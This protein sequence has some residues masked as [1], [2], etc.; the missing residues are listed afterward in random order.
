[1]AIIVKDENNIRNSNLIIPENISKNNIIINELAPAS[2][3]SGGIYTYDNYGTLWRIYRGA[4]GAIYVDYL[5]WQ[6]DF[7]L[8]EYIYY[9]HNV[10]SSYS[11]IDWLT[12]AC[13]FFGEDARGPFPY[14][15]T[16][17]KIIK[18]TNSGLT[19]EYS[20]FG[21]DKPRY[22]YQATASD[23]DFYVI[24]YS[25]EASN[26]P[27]NLKLY[28]VTEWQFHYL[29]D[30][31]SNLYGNKIKNICYA[32]DGIHILANIEVDG[33]TIIKHYL[34][35]FISWVELDD[36]TSYA[37][38]IHIDCPGGVVR[39][40]DQ[41]FI[42]SLDST[43]NK[44]DLYEY[45]YYSKNFKFIK[46]LNPDQHNQTILYHPIIVSDISKKDLIII[47]R[48]K[49]S[50][51]SPYMLIVKS[52][53][54]VKKNILPID[55]SWNE[56]KGPRDQEN[57]KL[58]SNYPSNYPA[59]IRNPKYGDIQIL[60]GVV[61]GRLN[62]KVHGIT[63]EGYSSNYSIVYRTN[64]GNVVDGGMYYS[65]MKGI[66]V[67]DDKNYPS[68]HY[69]YYLGPGQNAKYVF[70]YN[71]SLCSDTNDVYLTLPSAAQG[72]AEINN[73]WHFIG[74]GSNFVKHYKKESDSLNVIELPDMP[75]GAQQALIF[76]FNNKIY[77]LGG[78]NV[79]ACVMIYENNSWVFYPN[80]LPAYINTATHQFEIMGDRIYII[81]KSAYAGN[82]WPI[83][84]CHSKKIN[85]ICNTS[86]PWRTEPQMPYAVSVGNAYQG[87]NTVVAEKRLDN[88]LED[89]NDSG[90][91][92]YVFFS[93]LDS[94]NT[95]RLPYCP[96]VE[97]IS[98]L[99]YA[100]AA[101]T[102]VPVPT[103]DEYGNCHIEEQAKKVKAVWVGGPDNK[104]KRVY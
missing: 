80:V 39:C 30:I 101:W 86:I 13:P 64:Y 85:D 38:N 103:Y 5:T 4:G 25:E 10:S 11:T 96:D 79:S 33:T 22:M 61:S 20:N 94:D 31:P 46:N 40:D 34:W 41:L 48:S 102:K 60:G 91:F 55:V 9:W 62:N 99:F 12:V 23:Y 18:V 53:L 73:E 21:G 81:G 83:Q 68:Y 24:G 92:L 75:Y 7:D 28:S 8:N 52:I 70:R 43:N 89:P 78:R 44:Y 42:I 72:M 67:Y 27:T 97:N 29:C 37:P 88:G 45:D 77:C 1:M 26:A 69:F 93:G 51:N 58:G 14:L 66:V 90:L 56:Y 65:G 3:T 76:S 32:S 35:D 57:F 15:F 17:D 59:A 71:I 6:F 19:N 36:I 95:Y 104:A 49:N 2:M 16:E 74:C 50:A 63:T 82:D 98:N 100:K 87:Y 54:H 47:E 84:S